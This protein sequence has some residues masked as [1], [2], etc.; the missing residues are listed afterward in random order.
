MFCYSTNYTLGFSVVV[1]LVNPEKSWIKLATSTDG[2][3]L[4]TNSWTVLL[5][6]S[7]SSGKV[8]TQ[9]TG[10]SHRTPTQLAK[11][12]ANFGLASMMLKQSFIAEMNQHYWSIKFWCWPENKSPVL[13]STQSQEGFV[14]AV[15]G[16]RTLLA[17]WWLIQCT[18]LEG[19]SKWGPFKHKMS[20]TSC[21]FMLGNSS[22]ALFLGLG[23]TPHPYP[24]PLRSNV[25]P[26]SLPPFSSLFPFQTFH[27]F[28]SSAWRWR[29]R[30]H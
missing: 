29:R 27:L 28:S 24:H 9:T 23:T 11:W 1:Q 12:D 7:V 15:G 5:K 17:L 26:G 8:L 19:S 20:S 2:P 30:A 21:Y 16:V 18:K 3:I 25:S 14:A 10:S 22:L 4:V 13:F 6:Q